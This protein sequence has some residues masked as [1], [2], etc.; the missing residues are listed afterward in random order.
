MTASQAARLQV[1][2]VSARLGVP[3]E[4]VESWPQESHKTTIGG[5]HY[6]LDDPELDRLRADEEPAT[7]RE[8]DTRD[9][10]RCPPPWEV[11]AC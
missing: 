3:L 10:D 9:T 7:S 6:D 11:E 8:M 5:Q 4:T 2:T 1:L